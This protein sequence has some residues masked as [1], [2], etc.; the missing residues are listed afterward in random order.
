[1]PCLF[2]F[3]EKLY[4]QSSFSLQR[5]VVWEVGLHD[6]V[7]ADKSDSKAD[8]PKEAKKQTKSVRTNLVII[9]KT[10]A[11]KS[12]LVKTSKRHSFIVFLW[13]QWLEGNLGLRKGAKGFGPCCFGHYTTTLQINSASLVTEDKDS[14]KHHWRTILHMIRFHQK[15]SWNIHILKTKTKPVILKTLCNWLCSP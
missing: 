12:P 3:S 15:N 6:K 10:L 2:N 1:M 11:P 5:F 14:I 7:L 8:A 13:P 9:D 4:V